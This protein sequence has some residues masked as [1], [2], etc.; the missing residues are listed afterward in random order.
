MSFERPATTDEEKSR[1]RNVM[2]ML[3]DLETLRVPRGLEIPQN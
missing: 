3:Q 2:Q 1:N